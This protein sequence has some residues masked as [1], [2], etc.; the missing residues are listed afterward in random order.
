MGSL[1]VKTKIRGFFRQQLDDGF[2]KLASLSLDTSGLL[3]FYFP[4]DLERY[5]LI[6]NQRFSVHPQDLKDYLHI[7]PA[8]SQRYK[9]LGFI[10]MSRRLIWSGDWDKHVIPIEKSNRY[11]FLEDLLQHRGNYRQSPFYRHMLLSLQQGRPQQRR[12][13]AEPAKMCAMD[14]FFQG[15][16]RRSQVFDA[17]EKIDRFFENM[18]D[19]IS[20]MESNGY[21]ATKGASVP[22]IAIGRHGNIIK[23]DHGRHRVALSKLLRLPRLPVEVAAVHYEWLKGLLKVQRGSPLAALETGLQELAIS[24]DPTRARTAQ[25]A[26]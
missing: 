25:S 10:A 13:S 20:D 17:E 3:K 24:L 6:H 9:S 14:Q 15:Y 12:D 4:T 21:D 5:A 18:L 16:L 26:E 11:V 2:I 22:R 8:M 1:A 19:L 23:I 7:H